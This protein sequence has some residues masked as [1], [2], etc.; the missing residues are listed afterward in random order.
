MTFTESATPFAFASTLVAPTAWANTVPELST[1][2]T[3]GRREV[4]TIA[5]PVIGAPDASVTV[6]V[7]EPKPPTGSGRTD[8]VNEIRPFPVGALGEPPPHETVRA[9]VQRATS[10][11]TDR[12]RC[13]LGMV[14]S[15][16]IRA[17]AC[18]R[19]GNR[20][21][22]CDRADGPGRGSRDSMMVRRIRPESQDNH[23]GRDR[24]VRRDEFGNSRCTIPRGMARHCASRGGGPTSIARAG[25]VL[26]GKRQT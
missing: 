23:L 12:D 17:R 11:M 21:V 25:Q 7:S 19:T 2:A 10:G 13:E 5:A 1:E 18:R 8:G 3:A 9:D 4:Q 15:C 24:S 16:E 6:A 20:R 14:D 22:P 26:E